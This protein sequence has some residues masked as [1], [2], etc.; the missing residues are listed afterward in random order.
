MKGT[1]DSQLYGAKP[2]LSSSPSFFIYSLFFSF[3]PPPFF[4]SFLFFS[5]LLPSFSSFVPLLLLLLRWTNFLGRSSC[6]GTN[7]SRQHTNCQCR[8]DAGVLSV[9]CVRFL[10]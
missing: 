8:H 6:V 1:G 5:L 4:L 10:V 7:R 9:N 3:L 2:S